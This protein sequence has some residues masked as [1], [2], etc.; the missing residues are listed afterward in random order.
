M[1]TDPSPSED[2][3]SAEARRYGKHLCA[4]GY[5]H[6]FCVTAIYNID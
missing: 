3:F 2:L 1:F 6:M 4:S 5:K